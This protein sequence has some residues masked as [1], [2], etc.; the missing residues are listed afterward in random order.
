MDPNAVL[1]RW[2]DAVAV[3]DIEEALDAA[4]AL[5]TWMSRGGFAPDWDQ[6]DPLGWK[7]LTEANYHATNSRM[8]EL[9]SGDSD[10]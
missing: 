9:V 7:P 10:Y 5:G 2:R 6:V 8:R 4:A 1:R 3:G